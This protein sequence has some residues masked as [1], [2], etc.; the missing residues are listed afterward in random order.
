MHEK[1]N[2]QTCLSFA[3]KNHKHKQVSHQIQTTSI[4]PCKSN[5][6]AIFI[7]HQPFYYSTALNLLYSLVKVLSHAVSLSPCLI[8][9]NRLVFS[10][11]LQKPCAQHKTTLSSLL[12]LKILLLFPRKL[13]EENFAHIKSHYLS[14]IITV[15]LQ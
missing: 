1:T 10:Q 9:L 8:L 14:V 15:I 3:E 4:C 5:S 2:K 13:Q 7:S 12:Q 11:Q 6:P